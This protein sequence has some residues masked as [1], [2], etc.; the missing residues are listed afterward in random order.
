MKLTRIRYVIIGALPIVCMLLYGGRLMRMQIVEGA[1][2]AAR[3]DTVYTKEQTVQAARG[4]IVDRYGRPLAMNTRGLDVLIDKAFIV[5]GSENDVIA[6]LIDILSEQGEEWTDNLPVTQ[7]APFEF[8]PGYESEVA[9]LKKLLNVGEYATVDDVIFRL[10]ERYGLLEMS[11]EEARPIFGVRY[12]MERTGYNI[13]TPYTFASDL[14]IDTV[15]RI[16]ERAFLMPGAR[17]EESAIRQY[18]GGDVAPH[19]I[20]QIGPIYAEEYAEL[21]KKGYALNDIIGKSGIERAFEEQLRGVDGTRQIMQNSSGEVIQVVDKDP[22]VPGN[23]VVLTLDRDLQQVAQNALE[24]QIKHLQQTA[25]A[26]KGKEADVG[27]AVALDPKTG[28]VLAAA[29]Y[30]SYDLQSYRREYSN[31][32]ADP[33]NPLFNR[34]LGGLYNPGSTFKPSVGIGGLTEGIISSSSHVLCNRVYHFYSDYQ[35]TCMSAHGS[36][37]VV[38]ALRVSCNI[39]FYDTG[40]QLGYERINKYAKALGLGVPTG[41]E[42]PEATGTLSS[43][44]YSQ[45][46]GE[47][48][49]PGHVLQSSIG[50]LDNRFTPLQLANYVSTIANRG[51]RMDVS[52]VKSINSYSF[53]EVVEE[54]VPAVAEHLDSPEAFE[55]VIKGMVQASR[56]GTARATFGSY[57]VDV[58]SKTGTPETSNNLNST[59]ICFAPADDPQIAIAVVIENGYHGYTGAPVARDIMNAFFADREQTGAPQPYNELLD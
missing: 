9:S 50:Q 56:I 39:F 24:K 52:I 28:E 59:F 42:L 36:L 5:R 30:P 19:I 41:I 33:L 38:D 16:R 26:G 49:Y 45:S 11:D 31:L 2:Y 43:P 10:K 1:S 32:A 25:A 29:T 20:G 37:T 40:R 54:T 27:A 58:A 35:P 15:A 8:K 3:A 22:V 7:E 34:A 12:E 46:R 48:W 47:A 14:S 17:I 57:F 23:T 21:K 53:E 6:R 13:S 4:E 44:E 18:V 51:K 55:T